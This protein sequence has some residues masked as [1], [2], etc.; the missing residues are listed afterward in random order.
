MFSRLADKMV[1]KPKRFPIP[2]WGKQRRLISFEEGQL[3]VWTERMRCNLPNNSV[4]SSEAVELYVL[5]LVGVG[6]RA[7]CVTE[8]PLDV[9]DDLCGEVW[10]INPPG[11]G[12]STGRATLQTWASS[13]LTVFERLE[14]EAD[15]LPIL[16]S[17]NSLGTASALYIA[18]QRN[19]TGLILR[20]PPPLRRLIVGKH[21]WWNFRIGAGL[22]A[23]QVPDQLD[24]IA[25]AKLCQ[26]PAIFIT[27]EQDQIVPIRF[28]KLVYEAYAGPHQR[29]SLLKAGHGTSM[30]AAEVSEYG[31]LLEWLRDQMAIRPSPT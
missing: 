31:K 6:G 21:G 1:L 11:F 26:M 10:A 16:I 19:V 12:C 28:Q 14:R 17:A 18:S 27:S 15:G 3:E 23:A 20:N 13:A 22:I 7:E 4:D 5:K 29:L 2:V 25:S 30:T 9:W 8:Q 24:S